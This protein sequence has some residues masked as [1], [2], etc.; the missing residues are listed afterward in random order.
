MYLQLD[1]K[2]VEFMAKKVGLIFPEKKL[3][4]NVPHQLI[5]KFICGHLVEGIIVMLGM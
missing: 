5:K 4:M 1:R 2:N 3:F